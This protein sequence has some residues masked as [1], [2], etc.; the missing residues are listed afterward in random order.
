MAVTGQA[1]Q[2]TDQT[3]GGQRGENPPHPFTGY[4]L[5]PLREGF[6]AEEEKSEATEQ[7]E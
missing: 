6:H 3:V 7:T 1:D 2:S 4:L 5:Q